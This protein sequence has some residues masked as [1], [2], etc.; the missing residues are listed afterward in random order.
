MFKKNHWPCSSAEYILGV[1]E[2]RCHSVVNEI[3]NFHKSFVKKNDKEKKN[4]NR[5]TKN[6]KK[7]GRD[8]AVWISISFDIFM[9]RGEGTTERYFVP[10]SSA[11]FSIALNT[12][13]ATKT[14]KENY[15]RTS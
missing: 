6:K 10:R 5:L 1:V 3:R 2:C 8:A 7:F 14:T 15:Y 9:R 12:A 13:V 4:S 11:R